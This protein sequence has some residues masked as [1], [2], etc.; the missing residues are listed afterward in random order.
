MCGACVKACSEAMQREPAKCVGCD[1]EG[2]RGEF[3]FNDEDDALCDKCCFG[4]KTLQEQR[5]GAL[6]IAA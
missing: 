6:L 2:T 4:G 1:A 3:N 5:A